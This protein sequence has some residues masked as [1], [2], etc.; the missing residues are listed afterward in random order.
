MR[1]I[2]MGPPGAGKGTQAGLIAKCFDIPAISTG[3][4]FRANVAQGTELGRQARLFMDAGQYVPDAITNK[5]VGNRLSEPDAASG[6][7]LDGYPRTAAQVEELDGMLRMTGH[8]IDRVLCLIVD[9]PEQLVT[10]LLQRADAEGRTDDTA[11]VIRHRQK[12]YAE[13]TEPLLDVYRARG[14]LR[15]LSGAGDVEKVTQGLLSALQSEI[16]D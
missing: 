12:L 16:S 11:D 6:F 10:R 13:E 1:V 14:Q 15:M 7:V 8:S 3:D 2:L 5:M 9:D 4:I